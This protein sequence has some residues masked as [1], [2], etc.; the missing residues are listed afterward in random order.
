MYRVTG[1]Q[2]VHMGK[3]SVTLL[4]WTKILGK[5][6]ILVYIYIYSIGFIWGNLAQPPSSAEFLLH[7]YFVATNCDERK[8]LLS[9]KDDQ[10]SPSV[11]LICTSIC[12]KASVT[13]SASPNLGGRLCVPRLKMCSANHRGGREVSAFSWEIRFVCFFLDTYNLYI[14]VISICRFNLCVCV[15]FWEKII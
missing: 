8:I 4:T 14:E 2:P 15:F 3:D 10:P 7:L 11:G 12:F 13:K 5:P 6:T 1:L 9:S